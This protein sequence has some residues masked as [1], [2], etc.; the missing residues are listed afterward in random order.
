VN[1]ATEGWNLVSNP[2]AA[3]IN[4][5]DFLTEN[6]N[7]EGAVYIWDDNGPGRGSNADYIVAN[8]TVATNTTEAGGQTR[9]NQALGTAQGFFIKLKDDSDTEVSFTEE[10]RLKIKNLDASFFRSASVPAFSRINLTNTEGLFKQTIVGWVSGISDEDV[11]RTFDARVFSAS[12]SDMIYTMKGGALLAI[13][14]MSY[15]REVV[16]LGLNIAA[17]GYFTIAVDDSL[18]Q[19][20]ELYLRDKLTEE[21]VNLNNESYSFSS[22][23]GVFTERFELLTAHKVLGAESSLLQVYA[24]DQTLVVNLP[25]GEVSDMRLV[26]LSGK[27]VFSRQVK[28]SARIELSLPAGVYIVSIG[29]QSHKIILK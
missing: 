12:A 2:Y 11:D 22:D 14:G 29:G 20:Q 8:G 25:D 28:G 7:L 15:S 1:E 19:G 3:A 5:S 9:Y 18:A 27:Q 10:M 21:I 26:T 17:E 16:S 23:A 13:Q 4:V 6:P 24:Y